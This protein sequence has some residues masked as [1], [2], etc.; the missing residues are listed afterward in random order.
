MTKPPLRDKDVLL[1]R[2][3]IDAFVKYQYCFSRMSSHFVKE[4][5]KLLDIFDTQSHKETHKPLDIFDTQSQYLII[6]L[7]L[8][9]YPH[10]AKVWAFPRV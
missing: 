5:H 2:L 7:I 1:R 3:I 8:Y 4:T 6:R 10:D 9:A